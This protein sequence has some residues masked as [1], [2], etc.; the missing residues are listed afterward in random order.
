[1]LNT[2]AYVWDPNLLPLYFNQ[3]FKTKVELTS[4]GT[5]DDDGG[6]DNDYDGDVT[7]VLAGI[8][9]L[10]FG[11]LE[12][13]FALF[14]NLLGNYVTTTAARKAMAVTAC[15]CVSGCLFVA[16]F[17]SNSAVAACFVA[18]GYGCSAARAAVADANA[19]D[20][21]PRYAS[22][23]SGICRVFCRTVGLTFPLL[24]ATLTKNKAC[25]VI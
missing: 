2:V 18:V 25:N 17:T 9:I 4:Y 13:V 1:M 19:F 11:A 14:G 23:I 15:L 20:I 16:A 21:A 5:D 10:A 22:V 6:A 12:P 8:P 24:V 3:S 7:G